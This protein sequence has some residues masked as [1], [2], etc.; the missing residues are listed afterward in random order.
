MHMYGITLYLIL[1]TLISKVDTILEKLFVLTIILPKLLKSP[2]LLRME[3]SIIGLK[4]YAFQFLITT[5]SHGIQYGKLT[6]L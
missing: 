5:Q 6:R 3:D 4:V 1:I 2:L